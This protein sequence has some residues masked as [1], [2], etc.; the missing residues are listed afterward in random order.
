M[1]NLSVTT[2]LTPQ[3]RMLIMNYGLASAGSGNAIAETG[4]VL[5]AYVATLE[6]RVEGL[7]AEVALKYDV[8]TPDLAAYLIEL[9]EMHSYSSRLREE[10]LARL[11]G[12]SESD[13][14]PPLDETQLK[15][16]RGDA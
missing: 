6:S 8:I 7:E 12:L 14:A 2:K 16:I 1:A 5:M 4:G 13:V 3:A 11:R 10:A 15:G 9:I